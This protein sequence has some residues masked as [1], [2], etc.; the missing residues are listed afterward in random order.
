MSGARSPSDNDLGSAL[1]RSPSKY[2]S[3]WEEF[4]QRRRAFSILFLGYTPAALGMQ[5]AIEWSLPEEALW[6]G[7]PVWVLATA[8]AMLHL[9]AFLCPRCGVQP[10]YIVQALG[11]TSHCKACKISLG[12]SN[13]VGG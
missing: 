10:A 1:E 3:A 4:R 9:K 2:A 5:L 13:P 12:F 7:L 11:N 6:V 8:C